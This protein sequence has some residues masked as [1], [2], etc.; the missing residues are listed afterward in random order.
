MKSHCYG[1]TAA[2]LPT[3]MFN[4]LKYGCARSPV[5]FTS[6]IQVWSRYMS[7]WGKHL[8]IINN[9]KGES[10]TGPHEFFQG[11]CVFVPSQRWLVG[12]RDLHT[13]CIWPLAS[14]PT[15][16]GDIRLVMFFLGADVLLFMHLPIRIYQNLSDWTVATRLSSTNR[17][18]LPFLPALSAVAPP[19]RCT[20]LMDHR[21]SWAS[22]C[23]QSS[24]IDGGCTMIRAEA[25]GLET[26][27]WLLSQQLFAAFIWRW[28]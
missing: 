20:M 15:S 6:M 5:W 19:G 7:K 10:N 4:R 12:L 17:P 16:A 22:W 28:E 13:G 18:F 1:A 25:R 2:I 23:L 8:I 24:S 3:R 9:S 26:W 11:T 27:A 14:K 21:L